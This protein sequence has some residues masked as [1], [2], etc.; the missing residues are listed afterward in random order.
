[1]G[2]NGKEV[3]GYA[4]QCRGEPVGRPLHGVG[5]APRGRP[6]R[7]TTGGCSCKTKRPHQG[8]NIN[9]M[10]PE[11]ALIKGLPDENQLEEK[12]MVGGINAISLSGKVS[13]E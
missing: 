13:N 2:F 4:N 7:T 10:I 1:M 6:Y 12:E 9:G 3:R 8:R 5:S 11:E